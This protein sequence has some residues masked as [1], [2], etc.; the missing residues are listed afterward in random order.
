ME[1][2]V[3]HLRK[4]PSELPSSKSP[5]RWGRGVQRGERVRYLSPRLGF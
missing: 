5:D 1:G 4:R 2:L 3:L